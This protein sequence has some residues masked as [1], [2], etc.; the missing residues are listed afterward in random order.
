M[1]IVSDKTEWPTEEK[2]EELRSKGIVAYSKLS[3][4]CAGVLAICISLFVYR[5][6]LPALLIRLKKS[7]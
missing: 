2:L 1:S 5:D 3:T 6:N 7:Y 4:A